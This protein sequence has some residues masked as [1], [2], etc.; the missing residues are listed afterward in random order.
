VSAPVAACGCRFLP[1]F[2]ACG[3]SHSIV[4]LPSN[5]PGVSAFR[6]LVSTLVIINDRWYRS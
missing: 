2:A 3:C 4:A 1:L 6:R 5:G